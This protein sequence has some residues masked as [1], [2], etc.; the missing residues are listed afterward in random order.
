VRELEGVLERASA[1]ADGNQLIQP[2]H[3]PDS[4]RAPERQISANQNMLSME[5]L[6]RQAIIQAAQ[7]CRGNI[8]HMARVLG[9]GRTTVWRRMKQLNISPDLYREN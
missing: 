9:I 7:A 5:E 8:S 3:L 2:E 1:L 6:E 4:V